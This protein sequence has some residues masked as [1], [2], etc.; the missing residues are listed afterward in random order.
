[1]RDALE[2]ASKQWQ[3][4][5]AASVLLHLTVALLLI[6]H[7]PSLPPASTE[8]AINVELVSPPEP[9]KEKPVPTPPLAPPKPQAFESASAETQSEKEPEKTGSEDSTP[10]K[11]DQSTAQNNVQAIGDPVLPSKTDKAAQT[12]SVKTESQTLTQARKLY[13]KD[14]LANPHV[15]QALG[16]L[17]PEKRIIQ[18]C[19]IEALE[20]IR[21][22]RP[23]TLPDMLAR[24]SGSVSET[25]LSV[26][27]GAFRS[28]A[29]W[30]AIAYKCEVDTTTMAV[31]D[32][33]YNIGAAIPQNQWVPRQLPRD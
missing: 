14:A 22:H 4:G 21:H 28:H 12:A 27:D 18:I 20:Q 26:S 31:A 6:V 19:N 17:P 10:A 15:K 2:N 25:G 9:E 3:W 23:G 32:F 13:S 5:F 1:M 29:Q 8:Q 11:S 7:L 24:S 33:S 30:Y 16:R